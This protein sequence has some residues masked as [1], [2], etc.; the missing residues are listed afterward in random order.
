MCTT[1]V[2]ESKKQERE[3]QIVNDIR[4]QKEY[5]IKSKVLEYI[6]YEKLMDVEGKSNMYMDLKMV[7]DI[8]QTVKELETNNMDEAFASSLLLYYGLKI[9]KSNIILI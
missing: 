5:A 3:D 4:M 6:V 8:S 9:F 2:N 1:R 7:V